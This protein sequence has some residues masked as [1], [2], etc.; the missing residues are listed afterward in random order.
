MLG[1]DGKMGRLISAM[2]IDE[3][4]IELVAAYSIAQSPNLGADIAVLCGKPAIGVIVTDI[5]N[6]END[7]S[8]IKADV[9]VDFTRVEG[10]AITT[11]ILIHNNIGVVIG[12]TGLS[13]ELVDVLALQSKEFRTPLV[14]STNMAMGMNT[15]FKI[16]PLIAKALPNAD[17]EIIE[18][19]HNQKADA[20]SGTAI[21]IAEKIAEGINVELDEVAQYGRKKGP[22]MRNPG[23]KEIGIHAIRAGDIVG[24]H[25]IIFAIDGERIELTHR[26]HSRNCFAAGTIEAVKFLG[27]KNRKSQASFICFD[28]LGDVIFFN[29]F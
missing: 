29:F 23:H 7:L 24:E 21:T 8:T 5:A 20:P 9:A 25:T 6:L 4:S 1:A 12:T 16:A 27:Q 26:A 22:A 15:I 11:P 19:H 28:V 14:I 2:A 17:I 3:E 13:N 10:T 18:A